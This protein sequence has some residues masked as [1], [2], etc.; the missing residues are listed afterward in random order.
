MTNIITAIIII[1]FLDK[2]PPSKLF[3]GN[4]FVISVILLKKN[5]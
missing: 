2:F 4:N 5:L 3:S 1:F